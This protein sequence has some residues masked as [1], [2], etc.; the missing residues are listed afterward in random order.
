MNPGPRVHALTATLWGL[1][2]LLT[3]VLCVTS[4]KAISRL[5]TSACSPRSQFVTTTQM[6]VDH[7]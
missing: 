3:G 5:T 1:N 7:K 2:D 4:L 6:E